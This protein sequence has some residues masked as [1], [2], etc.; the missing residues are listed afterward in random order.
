MVL[1]TDAW[2]EYAPRVQAAAREAMRGRPLLE[3]DL[4]FS[5]VAY[6][7]RRNADSDGPLK[8]AKDLLQGIVY[9]N[10]S[11]VSEDHTKRLHDPVNPRVVITISPAI[12]AVSR[13]LD[14]D[15]VAAVWA[16]GKGL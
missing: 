4:S 11:Q 12:P 6:W 1:K 16:E 15:E 2:E 9:A 8:P 5:I 7:P 3:G 10:D 13:V 14:A